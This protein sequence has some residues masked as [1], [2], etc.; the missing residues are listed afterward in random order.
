MQEKTKVLFFIDGLMPGGKERRLAELLKALHVDGSIDFQLVLMHRDVHYQEVIDIGI[1]IHYL[2]RK[3]KKDPAIF[4][5][6][7]SL[8]K[9]LKPDIVHC[10]DGMTAFYSVPICK[11][12]K[13]KLINGMV[14]NAPSQQNIFNKYWLM[15]RL[16]FP[17]SDSIVSNSKAGLV[18][19]KAPVKKSIVIGNGFDFSRLNQVFDTKIIRE[20][21]QVNTKYLVGMVATFSE[22][23]DYPTYFTAA[24]MLLQQRDDITFFAIG[25]N[26]DSSV[27]NQLVSWDNNHNIRLLGRC[28]DVEDLVGAMDVCVLASFTEGI[29]NAIIEYMASAKPVVATDGGG[30]NELIVDNQTGYLIKI[31]DYQLLAE[32]INLLLNDKNLRDKMGDEGKKRIVENFS[33][34]AMLQKY[35]TLYHTLITT[36]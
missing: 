11:M 12:L 29:S 13:I 16:T 32:K 21:Y 8:C 33:I 25:N 27:A 9:Q 15:A 17:F 6:F 2:I 1:K 34:N 19:Y 36:H 23:K 3:S 31:G 26:T 20:K 5:R 35:I 22:Y 28:S 18:A 4:G 24:K 7:Y 30:T 14:T 10:W